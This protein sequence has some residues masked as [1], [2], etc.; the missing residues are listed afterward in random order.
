[1]ATIFIISTSWNEIPQEGK[2]W[3]RGNYFRSIE[4]YLK[5]SACNLSEC[6]RAM[7]YFN[8]TSEKNRKTI[9]VQITNIQLTGSSLTL[10]YRAVRTSDYTS[11]QIKQAV[12]LYY[13]FRSVY[14]IPFC[15][16]VEEEKFLGFLSSSHHNTHIQML[17]E[18]NN[19]S[20]IL[21]YSKQFQP[22]EMNDVWN[23]PSVLLQQKWQSVLK[24]S[25]RNFHRRKRVKSS[26]RKSGRIGKWH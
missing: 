6:N 18:K 9:E 13:S 8:K 2:F 4:P 10:W 7:V 12:K 11:H 14:E 26:L 16:P 5:D 22:F 3:W 19:W 20:G 25:K 21:E 1:M 15:I 23:V 17:M 24:I